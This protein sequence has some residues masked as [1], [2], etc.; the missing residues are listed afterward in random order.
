MLVFVTLNKKKDFI[1][2][3]G[4]FLIIVLGLIMLPAF[5]AGRKTKEWDIEDDK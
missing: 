5:L 2:S 4:T 1:M 3:F